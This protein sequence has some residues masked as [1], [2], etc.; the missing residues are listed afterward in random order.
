MLIHH[1]I[2]TGTGMLSYETWSGEDHPTVSEMLPAS[3]FCESM[4]FLACLNVVTQR[5]YSS[6]INILHLLNI[7]FVRRKLW[8]EIYKQNIPNVSSSFIRQYC[9]SVIVGICTLDIYWAFLIIR[10]FLFSKRS[11]INQNT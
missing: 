4:G 6:F 1:A 7:Y 2:F 8:L 9:K 10:G 3:C 5:K 11:V